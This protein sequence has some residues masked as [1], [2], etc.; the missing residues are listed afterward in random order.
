MLILRQVVE[1]DLAVF[2][3]HQRDDVA[4]AMAAFPSRDRAAFV[5]HWH[6]RVLLSENLTRAVVVDDQVAGYIGSWS[7]DGLRLV[8]YWIG[9][10]HW[11]KG[12]ATQALRAF[13]NVEPTRPLMAYV[14]EHNVGSIRVLEKCAF[15]A[16]AH[17]SPQHADGVAE[18]LMRLDS[19]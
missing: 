13:L 4:T 5:A 3:E 6:K 7:Q 8:A 9:R 17:E 14:A 15:R 2:Y 1:E 12:I 11:G 16:V 19:T 18:V 10:E